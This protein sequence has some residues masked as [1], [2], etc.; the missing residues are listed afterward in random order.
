M[1]RMMMFAFA[2][3]SAMAVAVLAAETPVAE[4]VAVGNSGAATWTNTRA[5]VALKLASIEAFGAGSATGTCV[6]S[7]VRGTRT[8]TVGSIDITS[9]A[10]IYRE[11]NTVYFFPGDK[12]VFAMTPATNV[13][14]EITGE[15]LP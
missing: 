10:G 8:N 11:T 1:K 14:I 2:A 15:L 13:A 3:L 7:R 9:N 4:V 6:V 12:L 5:Y